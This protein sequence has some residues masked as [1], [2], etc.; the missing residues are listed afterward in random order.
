MKRK[1]IESFVLGENFKA[2]I[3]KSYD[4]VIIVDLRGRGIFVNKSAE[5]T[6]G[7]KKEEM[8]G[9]SIT[10][11]IPRKYWLLFNRKI[12]EAIT[13]KSI[14]P[15]EIEIKNKSGKIIPVETWGQA[16]KK[17]GK[18]LGILIMIRDISKRKEAEE[19]LKRSLE[20]LKKLDAEKDRFITIAAHELKTPLTSIHGFTQLLQKEDVIKDIEAHNRYLKIIN[21][22]TDRLEN[23]V[24]DIL[25]LSKADLGTIKLIIEK[26]NLYEVI[27]SLKEGMKLRS[28]DK[29]LK[30]FFD[31][32]KGLPTIDTDREKL[33]RILLNLVDNAIKYTPRG[34]I[35]V[36]VRKIDSQIQ[37]SVADTG[38]G[39]PKKHFKNIFTRFYQVA[40]PYARKVEGIGLGLSICKELVQVMGGKIWF[41]SKFGKGTTFYFTLPIKRKLVKLEK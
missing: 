39:I 26:V 16:I 14:P 21:Q 4:A 40:S 29:G 9:N 27:E 41:K 23:L 36:N 13:G 7:Y 31:I 28:E 35:K 6:T 18:L 3:E 5:R 37:F 8:L 32:E 19:K 17:N 15:F 2:L 25:D 34:S 24:T 12:R 10:K 38:I 30:I 33:V 22:D 11:V 1:E 20:E